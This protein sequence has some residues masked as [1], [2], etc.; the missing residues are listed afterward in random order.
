[1][2]MDP[3]L[4]PNM[5][6]HELTHEDIWKACRLQ[7]LNPFRMNSANDFDVNKDETYERMWTL[8]KQLK[9]KKHVMHSL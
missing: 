8:Y 5:A 9:P 4:N 3:D 1:E 7:D 2:G 6:D